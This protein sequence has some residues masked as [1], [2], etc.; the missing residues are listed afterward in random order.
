MRIPYLSSA[1]TRAANTPLTR[2]RPKLLFPFSLLPPTILHPSF[3]PIYQRNPSIPSPHITPLNHLPN[4]LTPLFPFFGPVNP[5]LAAKSY[6]IV[7]TPVSISIPAP[8]AAPAPAPV[9]A[10]K[11]GVAVYAGV[12]PV[13]LYCL[14]WL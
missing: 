11:A 1:S 6:G 5:G 9:P 2:K 12:V 13:P 8:D 10:G 4:P 7:C 3:H 14:V